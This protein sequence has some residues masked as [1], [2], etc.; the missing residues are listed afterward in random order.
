MS[1]IR[2]I[3]A[4]RAKPAAVRIRLEI[5][6]GRSGM[7]RPK[8]VVL[9]GEEIVKTLGWALGETYGC[10]WGEDED[11]G[12]IMLTPDPKGYSAQKP[13]KVA[14]GAISIP[15]YTVSPGLELTKRPPVSCPHEIRDGGLIA[16][17]PP[18]WWSVP[19]IGPQIVQVPKLVP[20]S[21]PQPG[22]RALPMEEARPLAGNSAPVSE[23]PESITTAAEAVHCWALEKHG[24]GES[25]K[26]APSGRFW[27]GRLTKGKMP[28]TSPYIGEAKAFAS[29]ADANTSREALLRLG[30]HEMGAFRPVEV[31]QGRTIREAA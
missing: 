6:P 18:E 22:P 3:A 29:K 23:R 1:F 28:V 4:T 14:S 27:T 12:K 20:T 7:L 17:L 24:V 30:H 11:A 26:L 8:M 21:G 25:Y 31:K 5:I 19:T 2:L 15:V 10:L 16:T 13:G 9:I